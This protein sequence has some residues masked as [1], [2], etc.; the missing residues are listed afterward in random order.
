MTNLAM[1]SL[2]I[3]Y[4][5]E[6][7]SIFPDQVNCSI[8]MSGGRKELFDHILRAQLQAARA[9]AGVAAKVLVPQ[10]ILID[11]ECP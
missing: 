3:L 8:C 4:F 7:S 10:D 5:M 11:Q 9:H 1:E 2:F 6:K